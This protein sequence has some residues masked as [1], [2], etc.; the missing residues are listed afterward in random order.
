MLEMLEMFTTRPF[1]IIIEQENFLRNFSELF[2]F[3]VQNQ[4]N[5]TK[6]NVNI[7]Q[8]SKLRKQCNKDAKYHIILC[9]SKGLLYTSI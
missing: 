2:R 1:F 9:A 4:K 8:V 5:K 6:Q 3:S 7:L